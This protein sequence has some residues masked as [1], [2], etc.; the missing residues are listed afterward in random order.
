MPNYKSPWHNNHRTG[1][2]IVARL[3]LP[4]CVWFTKQLTSHR[5][6]FPV[7][8]L[9]VHS[10]LGRTAKEKEQRCQRTVIKPHQGR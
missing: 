5:T 3:W 10:V 4:K 6:P 7:Q 8:S 9:T 2:S 1:C